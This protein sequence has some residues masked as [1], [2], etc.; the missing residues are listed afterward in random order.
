MM[1]EDL[2]NQSYDGLTLEQVSAKRSLIENRYTYADFKEDWKTL[3]VGGKEEAIPYLGIAASMFLCSPGGAALCSNFIGLDSRYA[4]FLGIVGM[5]TSTWFAGDS[6]FQKIRDRNRAK[7]VH[8]WSTFKSSK[9]PKAKEDDLLIGYTTDKM[10]PF[11]IP[12]NELMRHGYILGMSGVGKTVV[13]KLMMYQQIV[14]GGGLIFVDG[15]LDS[16]SYNELYAMACLCGRRDDF[17]IINPGNPEE[18]NTYNPVL[19][20]DPDEVTARIMTLISNST[21]DSAFYRS[22]ATQAIG[23]LIAALQCLGKA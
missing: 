18:S 7:T 2:I 15:K 13:G 1:P 11:R 5:A 20:G 9:P 16:T 10:L 17:L 6:L 22:Q 14:R 12:A 4:I 23:V 8:K 21:G 3:E 19:Y